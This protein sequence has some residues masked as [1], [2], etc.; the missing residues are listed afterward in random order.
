[1][2]LPNRTTAAAA[3]LGATT[4]VRPTQSI[5]TLVY[6]NQSVSKYDLYIKIKLIG[7]FM[8]IRGGAASD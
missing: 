5:H 3:A 6:N 4:A 1:M 8:A 2:N 7:A